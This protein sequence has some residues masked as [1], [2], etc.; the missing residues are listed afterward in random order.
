M[1]ARD[2]QGRFIGAGSSGSGPE[3]DFSITVAGGGFD[4]LSSPSAVEDFVAFL[5]RELERQALRV[6][7]AVTAK[8]LSGQ[9]LRRRTG[10]LARSVTGRVERVDG[11]PAI[12]VGIFRGPAANYAGILEKGGTIKPV[13]A[14]ALAIPVNHALTPAGVARY[15]SPREYPGRLIMRKFG[16]SGKAIGALYDEDE[17]EKAKVGKTSEDVDVLRAVKPLWL[18]VRSVKIPAYRWL[19]KPVIAF[20]PSLTAD[21]SRRIREYVDGTTR[22]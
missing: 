18:L 20:L 14:K 22:G 10:S 2:S 16:Q 11:V 5:S 12:R 15:R 4:T 13:K 17:V 3:P 8:S 7:S 21:L 19:S 1:V 6:A 9:I